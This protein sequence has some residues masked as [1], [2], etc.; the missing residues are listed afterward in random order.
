MKKALTLV[1]LIVTP[2]MALAQGQITFNNQTGLVKTW[3]SI[4]DPTPVNAV[5]GNVMVELISAPVGTALGNPPAWSYATLEAFLA[6]NPGWAVGTPLA[7]SFNPCGMAVSGIFG[8][9][10]LSLNVPGR[11]AAEY[12]VIGWT[13]PYGGA[14][15]AATTFD[16]AQGIAGC[17]FDES[18]IFTTQTGD[19]FQTPADLPVST[20]NTFGGL[21]IHYMPEPS[22]F[23]L[24]GLGVLTLMLFRLRR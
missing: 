5:K 9:G 16:A 15:G 21:I 14:L 6:A 13:G 4:L 24:A 10:N 17:F 8:G 2:T 7:G 12:F 23:T 19:P 11:T 1:V 18:A 22:S 3:T 20:K